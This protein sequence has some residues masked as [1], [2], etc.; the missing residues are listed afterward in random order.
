M[1][2][3]AAVQAPALRIPAAPTDAP[4]AAY[5]CPSC[6]VRSYLLSYLAITSSAAYQCPS[7]VLRGFYSLWLQLLWLALLLSY[8]LCQARFM[9]SGRAAAAG[10]SPQPP[11]PPADDPAQSC[12]GPLIITP[13]AQ[14]PPPAGPKLFQASCP[15][16]NGACRFTVPPAAAGAGPTKLTVKCVHCARPFAIQV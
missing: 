2:S 1:V 3:C 15:R 14:S 5:Q 11:P 4:P 12:P 13:P 6:Q 7:C 16:C 10:A 9:V 8:L